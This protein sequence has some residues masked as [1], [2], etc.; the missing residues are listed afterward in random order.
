MAIGPSLNCNTAEF[1]PISSVDLL[2]K[3][4]FGQ[5]FQI[6]WLIASLAFWVIRVSTCLA[7]P[8]W[9]NQ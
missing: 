1:T 3:T 4:S 9:T 7:T 5:R 6:T 8:L 2:T